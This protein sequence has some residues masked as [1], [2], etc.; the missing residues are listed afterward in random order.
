MKGRDYQK[1]LE[2]CPSS[3]RWG[4]DIDASNAPIFSSVCAT[5]SILKEGKWPL[6]N[7]GELTLCQR[8]Q[9]NGVCIIL[10]GTSVLWIAL[11]CYFLLDI[12]SNWDPGISRGRRGL[13]SPLHPQG[14]PGQWSSSLACLVKCIILLIQNKFLFKVI[15]S[16]SQLRETFFFLS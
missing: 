14:L 5:I 6:S 16:T 13:C 4:I 12:I 11:C 9:Q 8:C 1:E 7:Y 3:C 15:N 10:L 2:W